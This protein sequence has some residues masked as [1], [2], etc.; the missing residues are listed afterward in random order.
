MPKLARPGWWSRMTE[1]ARARMLAPTD[2]RS[3]TA[4]HRQRLGAEGERVAAQF[5]TSA[6]YRVVERNVRFPV[7]EVDVIAWDGQTL[8]FVEVRS[9][10]SEEW[11]GP[12]A[13]VT[14][15]KRRRLIRAAQ[16][17]LQGLR[18]LP[19]YTRFDVVAVRWDGSRQP[20]VEHIRGAFDG[21]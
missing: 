18:E 12:L 21:S 15:R 14:E 13:S 7:G 5:L 9:T 10:S 4:H 11:G 20:T 8:C 6:G 16:W 3:A 17:Y 1:R 2:H 19:P